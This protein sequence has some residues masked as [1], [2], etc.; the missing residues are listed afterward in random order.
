MDT[1]VT[2]DLRSFYERE[3]ELELRGL[4]R[5]RRVSARSEFVSLLIAEERG[6]VLDFGAGPGTD[7]PGFV[8]AGI[9]FVGVDLAVGNARLA[10]KRGVAV[11]PSSIVEAPFADE[12]FEAGWSM[13]VFMHVPETEAASCA[14]AMARPLRAGAPL[15]VG[16]WGGHRRDEVE[17]EKLPG[18]RR[19][20]SLRTVDQNRELLGTAGAVERVEV[21]DSGPEGW[22]YQLFL[23]RVNESP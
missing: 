19:L 16:V 15:M 10:A 2:A 11:V 18:R 6:N 17:T 22:E 21:W 23:I 5:E 7:A 1:D 20:F 9:R 4:P 8:E 3:A 13:S 14:A 12:T